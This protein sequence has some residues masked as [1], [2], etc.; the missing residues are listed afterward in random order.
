[1]SASFEIAGRRIGGVDRCFVI[2]EAGV[3]HN[4]DPALARQLVDAAAHAGADAVKFQTFD[5]DT[6]AA[7]DAPQAEYQKRSTG[8]GST[9]RDLLRG[10]VLAPELHRELQ[11]R[12]RALGILFLSSPFDERSADF[13][14]SLDV[15]AFK[16]PSGEL[17]NH[18]LLAH[19]AA[20]GRPLLVSTGMSTLDEV[21]AAVREIRGHGNPPLALFHC[22][23]A[24]PARAEDAN[25]RAMAT[26]RE[27]FG[28]PVGWSDH[29]PGFE[30]TVAAVALGAQLIEKHL[31]LDRTLPGPDH[32]ASLDPP[33]FLEM[34]A[35]IR[36]ISLA[37]GDGEK[38]PV[39]AEWEIASVA[40]KSLHFAAALPTGTTLRREHL[41]ALRPGTGI[42]P[43]CL[44]DW[45][46]QVLSRP[47]V[48]GELL[49]E[50]LFRRSP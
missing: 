46:G 26:M 7:A 40:R 38:R 17:T 22:V 9:Q 14:E 16:I 15:P 10:L 1:M 18:P 32:R 4:G 6:L 34:M 36:R 49:T 19:L 43:A 48:V 47:V 5:P 37:L 28:V 45:C 23:S 50:E 25:L 20:K 42:S 35:A 21:R 11:T 27:A 31:T 39:E 24:Y 12:A 8:K 44:D 3:N 29:T 30:V 13:L 41:I 2:A 33:Q